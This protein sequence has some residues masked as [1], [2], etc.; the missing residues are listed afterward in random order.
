MELYIYIYIVNFFVNV[1]LERA[2]NS[3]PKPWNPEPRLAWLSGL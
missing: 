1:I 3:L 2:G